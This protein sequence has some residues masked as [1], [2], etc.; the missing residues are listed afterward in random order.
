MKYPVSVHG[1]NY[2][3]RRRYLK[4]LLRR[5]RAFSLPFS[6]CLAFR[7]KNRIER[8]ENPV[9][10]GGTVP[11]FSTTSPPPPPLLALCLGKLANLFLNSRSKRTDVRENLND[12]SFTQRVAQWTKSRKPR[13]TDKGKRDSTSVMTRRRNDKE[14]TD[15]TLPV[16]TVYKIIAYN[17][18]A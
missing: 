10:P 16:D 18:S 8:G 7:G 4:V 14:D 2:S 9:T 12:R 15:G 13:D 5:A 6:R 1:M 3:A 11:F 17:N